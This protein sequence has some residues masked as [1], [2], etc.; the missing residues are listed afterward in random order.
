MSSLAILPAWGS[1]RCGE[2]SALTPPVFGTKEKESGFWPT[3]RAGRPGSRPNGKGGKVLLEEVQIAEGA[4]K[5]G[6]MV[7][8]RNLPALSPVWVEWLMGF[9]LQWT[10]IAPSVTH[11]HPHKPRLRLKN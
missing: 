8:G 9:P 10:D 2:L 3:P 7:A 5:R 1:M 4:R 11:K 6:K